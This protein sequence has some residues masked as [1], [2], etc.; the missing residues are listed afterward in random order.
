MINA[1]KLVEQ[2]V[3]IF[4]MDFKNVTMQMEVTTGLIILM[5][6]KMD[7]TLFVELSEVSHVCLEMKINETLAQKYVEME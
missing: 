3:T 5:L 1:S 2:E 6:L 4:T 7:V